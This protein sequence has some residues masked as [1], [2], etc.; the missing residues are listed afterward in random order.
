MTPMMRRTDTDRQLQ[1]AVSPVL[2]CSRQLT[3]QVA[4]QSGPVP[5]NVMY[6][7]TTSRR[8]CDVR[9]EGRRR[10]DRVAGVGSWP[11]SSAGA[12]LDN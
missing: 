12:G 8:R 7:A 1:A 5:S 4:G 9:P 10:F 6:E 11:M 3:M 2:Q